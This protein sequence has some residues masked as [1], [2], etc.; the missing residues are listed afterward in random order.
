MLYSLKN[1]ADIF[2]VFVKLLF[3]I[4]NTFLYGYNINY[5][6]LL[7][8]LS[9]FDKDCDERCTLMYHIVSLR[10]LHPVLKVKVEVNLF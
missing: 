2:K 10:D 7:S 6:Q 4:L 1:K 9:Q 8:V 3:Y 5:Y